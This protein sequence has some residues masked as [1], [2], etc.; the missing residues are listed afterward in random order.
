MPGSVPP[1][2]H[3]RGGPWSNL[4]YHTNLCRV[5][6]KVFNDLEKEK[7]ESRGIVVVSVVGLTARRV[8]EEEE[9]DGFCGWCTKVGGGRGRQGMG[10]GGE[11]EGC[12][13]S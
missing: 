5:T 1:I 3:I 2:G 13:L 12:K 10:A 6:W 9:E 8:R 7:L 11:G 4:R